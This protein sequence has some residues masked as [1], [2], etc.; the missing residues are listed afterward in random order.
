[1][2]RNANRLADTREAAPVQPAV[3]AA[4]L[5]ALPLERVLPFLHALDM[6]K[7][8]RVLTAAIGGSVREAVEIARALG[9]DV[10]L[11]AS[12]V[13]RSGEK[14]AFGVPFVSFISC[15]V[16]AWGEKGR[17]RAMQGRPSQNRWAGFKT[18]PAPFV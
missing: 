1:M 3:F 5:F 8:C 6:E 10:V 4:G 7:V 11:A 13:D 2:R 16:E 12:F 17:P 9:G 15:E 14:A 18:F